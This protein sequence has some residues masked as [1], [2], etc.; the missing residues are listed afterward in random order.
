ME[1]VAVAAAA[2]GQVH[3]V[4]GVDVA[5]LIG[6]LQAATSPSTK[7]LN[8]T[9]RNPTFRPRTVAA[10]I[11]SGPVAVFELGKKERPTDLSELLTLSGRPQAAVYWHATQLLTVMLGQTSFLIFLPKV[12]FYLQLLQEPWESSYS[13]WQFPSW[14]HPFHFGATLF[15]T[16]RHLNSRLADQ[17]HYSISCCQLSSPPSPFLPSCLPVPSTFAL[18]QNN[19]LVSSP[20][21]SPPLIYMQNHLI[22]LGL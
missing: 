10:E 3:P 13:P 5:D 21:L 7:F 8:H 9:T 20:C 11:A 6:M 1:R 16:E 15:L 17:A 18:E 12:L 22:C 14:P 4:L 2:K 19:Y